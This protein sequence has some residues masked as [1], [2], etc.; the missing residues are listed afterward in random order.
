MLVYAFYRGFNAARYDE[1][2]RLI[3]RVEYGNAVVKPEHPRVIVTTA[4]AG[5][6][7]NLI[8]ERL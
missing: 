3:R 2:D 7:G 4:R 1:S 5:Y 8:A 6:T